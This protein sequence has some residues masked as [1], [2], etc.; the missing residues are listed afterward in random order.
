MSDLTKQLRSGV[1][2]NRSIET[3]GGMQHY[4]SNLKAADRI[5]ELETAFKESHIQK[6]IE[7]QKQK[8]DALW[9]AYDKHLTQVKQLQAKVNLYKGALDACSELPPQ[10]KINEQWIPNTRT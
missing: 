6:T 3:L 10:E 8:I 5:D 1:S 2:R 4:V 9:R 7:T